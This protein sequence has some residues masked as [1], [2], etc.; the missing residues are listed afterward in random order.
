MQTGDIA[1]STTY[2]QTYSQTL[3]GEG[4][5]VSRLF[6]KGTI[7]ITIAANIGE[8][9]IASFDVACPDSVVAISCNDSTSD[10]L[11]LQSILSTFKNKLDEQA[12]KN[13]QKNI[14]LQT[15]RPLQILTPPL[16]EQRKIAEI[17]STW[18]RAIETT[19]RLL[20]NATTQK[21]ALMQQLL[22]GKRRFEDRGETGGGSIA[23]RSGEWKDG[24]LS[25]LAEIIMG[26]SPAGETYNGVGDGV[27]LLN[28]P[29]EFTDRYPI[30]RQ[31]TTQP[32]KM[33]CEG[34]VLV[35][36][37]GSSTGRM[38]I[39]DAQY[40][41][42]R[43]VAAVRKRLNSVDTGYLQKLVT[44]LVGQI[45]SRTSGSTFPN[46]DKKSLNEIPILMPPYDE[47][48]RIGT[49]LNTSDE[50]IMRIQ[51]CLIRFRNEKKALMQQLLTG[52]R[53]VVV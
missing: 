7:L 1:S 45:I 47:Q 10:P 9:A 28:G 29:T 20:A 37:R 16:A 35:C 25:S 46:I 6:P 4:L 21:R 52:K 41:I 36:V 53:R 11:W 14:N 24:N 51:D 2:L 8:T 39:A 32:T 40:C 22:T 23:A 30:T 50:Q 33:C 34:D 3:N 12:T 48:R 19:E 18:D 44:S 43:G 31:W 49:I 5:A 42:G 17:L 26:Q 38:N 27:P 13:A 15:L